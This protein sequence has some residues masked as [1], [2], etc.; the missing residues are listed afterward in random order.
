MGPFHVDFMRFI[1]GMYPEIV[2]VMRCAPS[3][4]GAIPHSMQT[5][6]VQY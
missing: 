1:M 3:G 2:K 5:N 4:Q 6:A